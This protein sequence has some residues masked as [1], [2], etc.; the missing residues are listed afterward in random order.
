VAIQLYGQGEFNDINRDNRETP[1]TETH[2]DHS[3]LLA[4]E[5]GGDFLRGVAEAVPRP[6]VEADGE[7]PIGAGRHEREYPR[8]VA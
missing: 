8:D 7:G 6:I 3:G 1:M 2:M 4:T 5:D